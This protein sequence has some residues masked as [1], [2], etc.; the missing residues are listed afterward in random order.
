[1]YLRPKKGTS[2]SRG[3]SLNRP[4]WTVRRKHFSNT[5]DLFLVVFFK[6]ECNF[7]KAKKYTFL[8]AA[9]IGNIG[10]T[11]GCLPC[12][13]RWFFTF[14]GK[15]CQTP[16]AIEGVLSHE[17]GLKWFNEPQPVK[18]EGYCGGIPEG[19]VQVQFNV[20]DCLGSHSPCSTVS[21]GGIQAT[22]II[23]EEVEPPVA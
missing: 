10:F 15:E 1:M 20:G 21:H 2:L 22:K 11:A 16:S 5:C 23:I 6:Q 18:I 13:K 7:V 14:N 4:L 12:C 8:R 17:K 3:T 9:Y 19:K